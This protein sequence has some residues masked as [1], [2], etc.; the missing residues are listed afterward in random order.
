MKNKKYN[1]KIKNTM[2]QKNIKTF[3]KQNS[4]KPVLTPVLQ[5]LY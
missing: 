4:E 3:P 2:F 5:R 1:E